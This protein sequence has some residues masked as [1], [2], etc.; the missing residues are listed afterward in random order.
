ML[1]SLESITLWK[2]RIPHPKEHF[3]MQFA[4]FPSK[5]A[6]QYNFVRLKFKKYCIIFNPLYLF[7]NRYHTGTAAFAATIILPFLLGI[8]VLCKHTA[9]YAKT[10]SNS[11]IEIAWKILLLFGI[12]EFALV[13]TSFH[14]MSLFDASKKVFAITSKK[15]PL[16]LAVTQVRFFHIHI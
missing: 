3:Y 12:A 6:N 16:A 11:F 5:I 8:Y 2:T 9:H 4:L 13:I 1:N 7:N 15:S 10:T 14:G